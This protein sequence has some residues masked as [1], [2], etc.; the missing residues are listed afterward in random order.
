[1]FAISG[2]AVGE[3]RP[4][5]GGLGRRTRSRPS[6]SDFLSVNLYGRIAFCPAGI[7]VMTIMVL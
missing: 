4:V 6:V 5:A 1:M 2:P 7:I 3:A